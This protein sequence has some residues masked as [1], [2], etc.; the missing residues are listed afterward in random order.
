M[1]VIGQ[2]TQFGKLKAVLAEW[3]TLIELCDDLLERIEIYGI[4][5]YLDM[6]QADKKLRENWGVHPTHEQ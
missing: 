4:A 5:H 6:E 2:S 1:E 3:L